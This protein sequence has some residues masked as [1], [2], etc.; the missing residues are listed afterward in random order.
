[1][2]RLKNTRSAR[3]DAELDGGQT[4]LRVG[5]RHVGEG[6]GPRVGDGEAIVHGVARHTDGAG[7]EG[8]GLLQID[9]GTVRVHDADESARQCSETGEVIVVALGRSGD[10]SDVLAERRQLIARDVVVHTDWNDPGALVLDQVCA[11]DS[12]VDGCLIGAV[13]RALDGVG[14][15]GGIAVG[16]EEERVVGLGRLRN[17]GETAVPVRATLRL[18]RTLQAVDVGHDRVDAGGVGNRRQWQRRVGSTA[19][20]R[21]C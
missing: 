8:S 14:V 13:S 18:S 17:G 4:G 11:A 19:G 6:N 12:S 21:G 3:P 1:M 20:G 7:S 2:C 16:E 10:L 15:L 9:R 5:Q